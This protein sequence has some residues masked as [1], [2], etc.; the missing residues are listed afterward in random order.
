MRKQLFRR[1]H[2]LSL[3]G[4]VALLSAGAVAFATDSPATPAEKKTKSESPVKV[5]EKKPGVKP[6][7]LDTVV[8]TDTAITQEELSKYELSK[9]PGSTSVIS[10]KKVEKGRV[11]TAADVLKL[12]PGVTA[13]SAGGNDALRISIRGSG[14]NR[15]VGSFREGIHFLFDGL[16]VTGN[17]GTPFE[18]F[19][20]LGLSN[21]EVLRGAAGLKY[22]AQAQGGAIN[23][24][25]QTGQDFAREGKIFNLRYESGS[26]GYNKAYLST[27]GVDG[28]ADWFAAAVGSIRD[29]YQEQSYSKSGRFIG[30]AGYKFNEDVETRFYFRYG[31]TD[32]DQPGNLTKAE[33]QNSPRKANTANLTRDAGRRQPGSTWIANKTN[34]KID[35]ES[36]FEFGFVYHDYPIVIRGSA[37]VAGT[38]VG[39]TTF[40]GGRTRTDWTDTDLTGSLRYIRDE[41]FGDHQNIATFGLLSN[42]SI[43]AGVWTVTT[44]TPVA[45]TG[46]VIK[47]NDYSGSSNNVLYWNNRFEILPKEHLWFITDAQLTYN[48][49]ENNIRKVDNIADATIA[50]RG[51]RQYHYDSVNS[52]WSAGLLY[53]IIPEQWEVYGTASRTIEPADNWK[54]SGSSTGQGAGANQLGV[55]ELKESVWTTGE[56]GTRGKFLERFEGSLALYHAQIRNELLSVQTDPNDSSTRFNTNASPTVHQGIEVGLDTVLWK[57]EPITSNDPKA[58]VEKKAPH[59]LKFT[60]AYTWNDF[61][62]QHDPVFGKNRLPGLATHFYQGELNY[63]HSSGFYAG[64]GANVSSNYS[65]DYANTYSVNA[66]VTY[67]AKIGYQNEKQGWEVFLDFRNLTG[68][69]YAASVTPVFLSGTGGQDSAQLQPGDGFGITGGF[70]YKY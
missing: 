47:Q 7:Q 23:Y 63:E 64:L 39:G 62:F 57:E 3:S 50:R 60:Q 33:I 18:L 6:G 43:Q 70:S 2:R 44:G 51:D 34:V 8:V 5:E 11:G 67:D 46:N 15:A 29:G 12:Q 68:E 69:R 42:T 40:N 17:G 49:R 65:L 41:H 58:V 4:V 13:V 14:I 55:I 54:Y 20:P 35:D 19:E 27:G 61:Y 32:F 22:G 53:Q 30:N 21:T 31:F 52:Q 9:I 24:V 28:K 59:Q 48:R 38:T 16:P 1:I 25:T 10:S 56:I 37:P 66:Y 45:N 26:F 36:K